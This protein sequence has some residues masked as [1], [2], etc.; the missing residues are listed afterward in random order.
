MFS[1]VVAERD[2]HPRVGSSL[3]D[4]V[5]LERRP[6]SDPLE[7]DMNLDPPSSN[8]ARASRAHSDILALASSKHAIDIRR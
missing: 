5:H 1:E 4:D 8:S 2:Q 3:L 7:E 6:L